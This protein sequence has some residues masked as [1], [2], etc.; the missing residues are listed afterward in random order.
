MR[1]LRTFGL[2]YLTCLA[3]FGVYSVWPDGILD[4]PLAKYT[5]MTLLR[6]LGSILLVPV[7]IALGVAAHASAMRETV[8]P[9]AEHDPVVPER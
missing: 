4:L 6:I 5:L 8:R 2:M 1:E 7:T 3:A 9:P